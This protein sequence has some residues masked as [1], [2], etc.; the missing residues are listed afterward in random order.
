MRNVKIEIVDSF[1]YEKE[2]IIKTIEGKHF[3]KLNEILLSEEV[4]FAYSVFLVEKDGV[5]TKLINK[6]P[7]RYP[8]EAQ[9]L[10]MIPNYTKE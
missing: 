2:S 3:V 8:M 6:F 5:V 4:E 10:F 1:V 7:P 9:D